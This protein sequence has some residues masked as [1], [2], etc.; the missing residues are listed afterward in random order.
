MTGFYEYPF[1]EMLFSDCFLQQ[2]NKIGQEKEF[3]E[4]NHWVPQLQSYRTGC[5]IQWDIWD[6]ITVETFFGNMRR[7]Y[8]TLVRWL[9]H[10][11]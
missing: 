10:C 4:S 2:G 1:L 5:L 8:T 11:R 7:T 3:K 9:S 6:C